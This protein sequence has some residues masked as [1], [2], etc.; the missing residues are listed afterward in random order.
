MVE[1][2]L[3]T[4]KNLD[5]LHSLFCTNKLAEKC[6][7]M[8]HI[9][10]V[11]DFHA[12]GAE[13]NRKQFAELVKTENEPIG[14]LAYKD[15]QVVGWCAV[16]PSSRYERAVKT[17]SYRHK[18]EDPY[19]NVWLVPCFLTHPDSRGL[20]LSKTLLEAAV[21]LAKK[22]NAEAIDGFP[23]T[24]EKRRSSGQIHVGFESTFTACGF[25]TIRKPSNS[26]VVMRRVL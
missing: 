9:I 17:P 18:G 3:V 10:S 14:L 20:G 11:K 21:Q 25:E 26:R 15:K 6:W 2:K 1:T 23:F 22:H 12:G 4:A 13:K 5:D 24:N 16:G 7:C 19:S 8:W